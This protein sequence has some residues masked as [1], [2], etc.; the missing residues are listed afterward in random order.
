[1]NSKMKS[2]LLVAH[3]SRRRASNDEV[4]LLV[5]R[6]RNHA[7]GQFASIEYAFLELAKPSIPD[8]ID[9]LVSQ[10]CDE[11]VVLP[12]FLSAGTHVAE[13]IPAIVDDKKTQY[14][15]IPIELAPHIGSSQ[16]ML[17]LLLSAAS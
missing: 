9:A 11:I 16:D 6:L 17:D 12:Y 5:E 4:K 1:M 15:N 3:G 13:D 7:S 10:G 2:L 8:A 14:P